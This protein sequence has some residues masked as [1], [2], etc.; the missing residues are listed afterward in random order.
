MDAGIIETMFLRTK[1]PVFLILALLAVIAL[2]AGCRSNPSPEPSPQQ[3]ASTS[4]T[5]AT[6]PPAATTAAPTPTVTPEPLALRVNGEGVSL[7]EFDA[8]LIQ[9]QEADQELGKEIA[10]EQQ[11]QQVLD[12]L[13]DTTLLAQGATENGFQLSDQDLQAEIDRLAGQQGGQ[14][15]LSDWM[16]RYGYNLDTLRAALRRQIAA[17]WQRDQ[18]AAAVPT[19]AEQIHARQIMTID[20]DTANR[21]MEQVKLPG[22]NFAAQAYRYDPLTG[23]DLGWFPRGYLTQP[24]VEEAAFQLQ[25]GEISPVIH[26]EIGYH[27]VQVIERE[28]NRPISPDARRVL[29]HEALQEWL[30]ARREASSV[31]DLLE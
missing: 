8:E 22:V 14:D 20:E 10:T 26:S 18:I 24:A 13:I 6:L 2:A 17:A 12:N 27:I 11:Q 5:A 7:A 30:Q 28:P 23:G 29:A 31:E 25:P 15:K 4:T 1:K 9:L 21:A 19:E 3:V 16:S